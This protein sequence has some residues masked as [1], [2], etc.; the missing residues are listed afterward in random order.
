MKVCAISDTHNRHSKIVIPECDLLIHCGDA[1]FQ[2]TPSELKNFAEWLNEQEAGHIVIIPGNHERGWENNYEAGCDIIREA[3]P[4]VHILND[5][6]VHIEGLTIWGSP[7][8]PFF[9]SWAWNRA[10]SERLEPWHGPYI[11]KHWDLIPE[12]IDILVTHGPP[13][14][15][16]DEVKYVDQFSYDPPKFVGCEDLLTRVKEVK[17]RFHFFGHIHGGYGEH[18][19][20][21][22][23]FYNASTC[24]EMYAPVNKPIEVTID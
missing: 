4:A 23:S 17:P 12:N 2:G 16:L 19:A 13:Y 14:G 3:C 9:H 20:D 7:V 5:N 11:K 1:T 24:D 8:T 15:I 21:G 6:E 10:R 18:H 22:T